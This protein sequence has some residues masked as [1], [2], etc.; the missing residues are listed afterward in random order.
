MLA[1]SI[2]IPIYNGEEFLE[3][4]LNSLKNQDFKDYEVIAVNDCSTDK[5]LEILKSFQKDDKRIRIISTEQNLGNAAKAVRYGLNFVDG[6]YFVYSS[7]DDLFSTDWLKEMLRRAVE[8]NADATIPDLVFY[9]DN[10]QIVDRKLSG[11][12]G[13]K[14]I[15]LSAREAFKYSL[16]W[17]IPGNALWR[18]SLVKKIG[19]FDFGMN[20]DEYSVRVFFLNCN[21][22]VFSGGVFLYRQNNPNA[23][24]K[25]FSIKT[26]ETTYTNYR[27]WKL[28]KEYDIDIET[29]KS[30]FF[31]SL[32][33]LMNFTVLALSKEYR[34]AFKIVKKAYEFHQTPEVF[35]WLR[36]QNKTVNWLVLSLVKLSLKTHFIFILLSLS[37]FYLKKFPGIKFII[38]KIKN[39]TAVRLNRVNFQ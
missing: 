6:E 9:N 33:S 35:A 25:K 13:N 38:K 36:E 19:Y 21:K 29:Q 11:I 24:T 26:F 14:K 4:T 27:L 37:F 5:S 39:I 16:N 1:I 30:L 23:I 20:A 32:K 2:V 10:P 3:E 15:V 18:T 7:Q 12:K 28:A 8:T 17:T 34:P 31:S 22:I